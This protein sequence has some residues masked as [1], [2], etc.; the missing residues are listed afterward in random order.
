MDALTDVLRRLR[1]LAAVRI[2]VVIDKDGVLVAGDSDGDNPSAAHRELWL[3]RLD[4]ADG[5][6]RQVNSPDFAVLFHD[7]QAK[8]CTSLP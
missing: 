2:A 3:D 6:V 8:R 5:L 4:G 7:L 1:R